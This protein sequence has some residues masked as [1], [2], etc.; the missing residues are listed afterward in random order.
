MTMARNLNR[1][2]TVYLGKDG[3]WHGRV[4]VARKDDGTL[5]RRHIMSKSKGTVVTKVRALERLRDEARVPK[6]GRAWTVE[7]WLTYW[8]EEI[9]RPN[10]RESSYNAYKTRSSNT[11]SR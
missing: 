6:P 4:T 11:S 8:L 2:S 3:Y 5:D 1:Q 10:V 9:A 7:K